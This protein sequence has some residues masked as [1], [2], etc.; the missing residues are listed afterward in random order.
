LDANNSPNPDVTTICRTDPL[1]NTR[2]G[3]VPYVTLGLGR[4]A[5]IDP[6]GNFF[7]YV[8]SNNE[9]NAVRPPRDWARTASFR[10]GSVGDLVVNDATTSS[11]AVAV[12]ISH[13]LNGAGAYT[14]KGTQNAAPTGADERANAD[15]CPESGTPSRLRC[16]KRDYSDSSAGGGGAFDDAVHVLTPTVLLEPLFQQGILLPPAADWQRQCDKLR[17]V[18][19]SNGLA[20]RTTVTPPATASPYSKYN[21]TPS[22]PA[23]Q[24]S[25]LLEDPYKSGSALCS[26]G[27]SLAPNLYLG[28]PTPPSG[29]ACAA[30]SLGS[31]GNLGGNDDLQ[32]NI[33]FSDLL[34]ALRRMAP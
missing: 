6:W 25:G 22:P 8:L 27:P 32:C 34:L 31:D 13:G 9:N 4:E 26:P 23:P 21:I 33:E 28:E 2:H 12:L 18:L 24:F 11:S 7:S 30:Q 3:V 19:L 15:G 16:F 5:V 14:V 1:T 17:D 20:N 29:S 10:V